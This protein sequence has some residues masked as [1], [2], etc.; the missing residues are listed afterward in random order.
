MENT[1]TL[2]E[3]IFNNLSG[4]AQDFVEEN[5]LNSI[6]YLDDAFRD[7]ADANT[8]IYT[9]DQIDFYNK[10]AEYCDRVANE[11]CLLESF[12]PK[13]DSIGDLVAKAGSWGEYESIYEALLNDEDDIKKYYA[14]E[15][16]ED[17]GIEELKDIDKDF[18]YSVA[19]D[20]TDIDELKDIN[21]HSV[22]ADLLDDNGQTVASAKLID[23]QLNNMDFWDLST[24]ADL[25]EQARNIFKVETSE[26]IKLIEYVNGEPSAL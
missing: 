15:R 8:S 18:L 13:R 24:D 19:E 17:L 22:W 14:L 2:K 3:N 7:F 4:Y 12:D 1:K 21:I 5:Y 9:V 26:N 6:D 10:N 11:L 25:Y 23:D 16:A 20:C